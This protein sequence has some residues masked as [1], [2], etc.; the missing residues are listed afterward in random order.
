MLA[1]MGENYLSTTIAAN[2]QS[3]MSSASSSAFFILAVMNCNSFNIKCKSLCVHPPIEWCSS[4]VFGLLKLKGHVKYC[5]RMFGV[6]HSINTLL[7]NSNL[8]N[9]IQKMESP[10]SMILSLTEELAPILQSY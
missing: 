1:I 4:T 10:A 9:I 2:F 5:N 7:I 8:S 6:I 3:L